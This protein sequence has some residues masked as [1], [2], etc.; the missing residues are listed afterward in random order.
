MAAE[1]R[2]DWIVAMLAAQ[3]V[4]TDAARAQTHA[5]LL[6]SILNGA[7]PAYARLAFEEEPAGYIAQ[8]RRNA[9]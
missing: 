9:P 6:A 8:Q 3:G 5:A 1:I 7:A 2:P 4:A